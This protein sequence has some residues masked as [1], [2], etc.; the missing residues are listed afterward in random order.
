MRLRFKYL[1]WE[2]G[3]SDKA[4]IAAGRHLFV[5][6]CRLLDGELFFV[7]RDFVGFV[8]VAETANML[9]YL[10]D[11]VGR[12]GTAAIT[13]GVVEGCRVIASRPELAL[14]A[15][16]GFKNGRVVLQLL[17]AVTLVTAETVGTTLEI[18]KHFH[19]FV[20]V[21]ALD[22]LKKGGEGALEVLP[23]V[24]VNTCES[25]VRQPGVGTKLR[26]KIKKEKFFS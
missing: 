7:V 11:L 26:L 24:R 19:V 16:H 17:P 2:V 15:L 23:V 1:V 9:R 6:L 14:F 10:F 5:A 22:G 4:K 13:Y 18:L 20:P 21:G 8:G 3:Q 25:V 12:S